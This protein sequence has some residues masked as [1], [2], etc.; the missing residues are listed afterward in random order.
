MIN[1]FNFYFLFLLNSGR[2]SL[3]P[4]KEIVKENNPTTNTL[5]Y[6]NSAAT[7]SGFSCSSENSIASATTS[8]GASNCIPNIQQVPDEK[9]NPTT[10]SSGTSSLHQQLEAAP[11]T[12]AQPLSLHNPANENVDDD[13]TD[14]DCVIVYASQ[15][16]SNSQTSSDTL[17]M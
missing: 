13:N 11:S 12:C 3:R 1:Y 5:N 10:S 9:R 14:D 7:T 15:Q 6:E 8:S 17:V 4:R 16:L 2:L